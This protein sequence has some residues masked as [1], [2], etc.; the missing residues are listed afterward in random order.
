M[1]ALLT[2]MEGCRMVYAN[3]EKKLSHLISHSD[4]NRIALRD[5][6]RLHFNDSEIGLLKENLADPEDFE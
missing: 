5:R 3:F 4:E 1:K 6:I 2:V